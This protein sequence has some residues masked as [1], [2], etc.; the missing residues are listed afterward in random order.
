MIESNANS[1]ANNNQQGENRTDICGRGQGIGRGGHGIGDRGHGIS[2]IISYTWNNNRKK[3]HIEDL[4][5]S[6]FE[7]SKSDKFEWTTLLI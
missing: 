7:V 5:K 4:V 6:V 2:V 1:S 3:F